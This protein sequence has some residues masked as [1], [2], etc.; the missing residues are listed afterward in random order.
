[1]V[2]PGAG[3]ECAVSAFVRELRFMARAPAALGALLLLAGVAAA[4]VALGLADASRQQAAIERTLA[5]QVAEEEAVR[6]HAA[7]AGSAAYYTFAPTWSEPSDLAFAA[8]GQRDVA[9]Y[10]LRIRALAL[11]GQLYEN[12]AGNPEL[13]L[14]GRFDFAFVLVYLAPLVLIAL[15]HDLVS[16]EREAGRLAA[17]RALPGS[18]RRLWAARTAVRSLGVFGALAVPLCAGMAVSGTAPARAAGALAITALTVAFWTAACVL[19]ATRGGWRSAVNATALAAAWFVLTLVVPGAAHLA[20]NAAVPIPSGA[21]LVRDSREAVHD[22]WDLP[23]QATLAHFYSSHPEWS[24]SA[25]LATTFHWKWYF[26]FQQLGDE[27]VA[28][29]SRAYRAGIARRDAAAGIVGVLV[30]PIGLQRALH[31][32]AGTDV[33]A[34][35]EYLDAVRAYHGELRRFYY[36]YLFDERPFEAADWQR[37]PR[38]TAPAGPDH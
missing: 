9:P 29:R 18:V 8:L 36:P 19:V 28:E 7:D 16:G 26:A 10:L 32:L 17:L 22:A 33:R 27:R 24:H 37:M 20:V 3:A 14:P 35:L 12:E 5:L 23:R 30:P 2:R 11:E 38:W 4:A 1:M 21:E 6:R 31:R 34:Q 15:L 25:P 13:A